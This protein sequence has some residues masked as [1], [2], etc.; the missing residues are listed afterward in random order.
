MLRIFKHVKR[1]FVWCPLSVSLESVKNF[2]NQK[3]QEKYEENNNQMLKATRTRDNNGGILSSRINESTK[4]PSQSVFGKGIWED[5]KDQQTDYYVE[6]CRNAYYGTKGK[7]HGRS[8][9]L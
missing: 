6:F 9:S 1:K 5:R 4:L 3:Y 2:Q 8:E 7:G